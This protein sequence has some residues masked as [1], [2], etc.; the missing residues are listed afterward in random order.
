MPVEEGHVAHPQLFG[1]PAYARPQ[2]PVKRTPLPPDPDDLPIAAV[3]THHEQRVATLLVA[4]PYQSVNAV[5]PFRSEP[6]LEPRP[7]L[8]RALARRIVRRAS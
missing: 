7:L 2:P 6:R 5:R 4:R 3:Q 1:A 8:L